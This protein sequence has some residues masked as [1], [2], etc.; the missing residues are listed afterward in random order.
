MRK[1]YISA[2]L[3][4]ALLLSNCHDDLDKVNPNSLTSESY[5]K[6]A[7]ELQLAVTSIYA[8]AHSNLLV[9]REWFFTHSLRSSDF[10]TGGAQ[11]EA[12]RAQILNGGSSPDNPVIGAIW[13]GF[14]TVIHRANTVI[15][16]GPLATGDVAKRDL[17]VAEARFLRAWAAFKSSTITLYTSSGL[18]RGWMTWPDL[19]T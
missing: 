5:F 11:L 4:A 15:V 14:Y 1:I 18:A 3:V 8:T 10:A 6:T 12:P 7:D 19:L 2:C 17:M 13:N 9:A 16:N